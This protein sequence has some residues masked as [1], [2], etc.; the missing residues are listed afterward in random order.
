[1]VAALF[2]V[3]VPGAVI[4]D[5]A[6]EGEVA[7]MINASL[8]AVD[9]TGAELDKF[10]LYT[11]DVLRLCNKSGMPIVVVVKDTERPV[12]GGR[13]HKVLGGAR[14][15]RLGK[16]ECVSR[17]VGTLPRGYGIEWSFQPTGEVSTP[18]GP[19]GGPDIINPPPPPPAPPTP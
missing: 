2:G 15:V 19:G 9:A 12:G 13:S 1:M 8:K 6:H 5:G 10:K 14:S 7:V 18:S 3:L 17:H 11:G 16:G 4:A